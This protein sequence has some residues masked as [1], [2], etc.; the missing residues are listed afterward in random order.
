[1][2]SAKWLA[3]QLFVPTTVLAAPIE[4]A[5]YPERERAIPPANRVHALHFQLGNTFAGKDEAVKGHMACKLQHPCDLEHHLLTFLRSPQLGHNE[6]RYYDV[7]KRRWERETP[8][9]PFWLSTRS[10]TCHWRNTAQ[11]RDGRGSERPP[12]SGGT[13]ALRWRVE[14]KLVS[15]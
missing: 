1:M 7:Q 13:P 4:N 6:V 5:R 14:L 2:R 12:S 11:V 9:P 8:A 10:L 3:R 15:E